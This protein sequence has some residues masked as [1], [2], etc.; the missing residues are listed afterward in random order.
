MIHTAL[1]NAWDQQ[2]G[3]VAEIM[4]VFGLIEMP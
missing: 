2:A 1:M 4:S 3:A